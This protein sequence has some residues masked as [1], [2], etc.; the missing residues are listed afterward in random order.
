MSKKE[1]V[2]RMHET[3]PLE[4]HAATER[5]YDAI[6]E[7]L[8]ET[9]ASAEPVTIREFG[10]FTVAFRKARTGRNPQTGES[11]EIPA[12]NVV[13]FSPGKNL[14]Q[15]AAARGKHSIE[16]WLDFRNFSRTIAQQLDEL[17]EHLQSFRF[18]SA[19]PD[20]EYNDGQG[21]DTMER[22]KSSYEDAKL[23]LRELTGSSGEAWHELRQG[24]EKAMEH[25]SEAYQRAKG[26]F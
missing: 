7:S 10:S 1:L 24:M 25:L 20:E 4:S 2:N 22:L 13:R 5:A 15:A 16:E 23:K 9:L 18:S 17:K 8:S 21:A 3:A 6:I 26:K 19:N 14:Q 12:H 11:L